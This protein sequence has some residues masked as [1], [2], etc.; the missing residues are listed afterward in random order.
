[1]RFFS[2][3]FS[4]CK[5]VFLE[6][7]KIVRSS[8]LLMK[9]R[10]FCWSFAVG[11]R[12]A[13]GVGFC[14]MAGLRPD[15]AH[16]E[17]HGGTAEQDGPPPAAQLP[18]GAPRAG[19][20]RGGVLQQRPRGVRAVRSSRQGRRWEV[21]NEQGVHEARVVV[22]SLRCVQRKWMRLP[23]QTVFTVLFAT[24]QEQRL[25]YMGINE[26]VNHVQDSSY[27][28]VAF[29]QATLNESPAKR[30]SGVWSNSGPLLQ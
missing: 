8:W 9:A 6:I 27:L 26:C 19:V 2:C 24:P 16:R 30:G 17:H 21:G 4:G 15:G 10:A 29:L 12:V 13:I 25:R 20:E 7:T 22:F 23:P 14:P 3:C 5:G 18:H 1:M 28:L 11:R